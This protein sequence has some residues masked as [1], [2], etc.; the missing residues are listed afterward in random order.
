MIGLVSRRHEVPSPNSWGPGVQP[1]EKCGYFRP[2]RRLE[3]AI[4]LVENYVSRNMIGRSKMS[5]HSSQLISKT[6]RQGFFGLCMMLEGHN[7]KRIAEP[8]FSAK[9]PLCPNVPNVP[10]IDLF[11]KIS[12]LG[13]E[14]FSVL[15]PKLE[16][17]KA[18]K[19]AQL[20]ISAKFMF[21]SKTCYSPYAQC[22]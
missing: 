8:D 18:S 14:F 12:K 16:A 4:S 7:G 20:A 11:K 15:C 13:H 5:V 22:A 2:S 9:F 10:K 3:I 19:M 6:A 21:S 17:N 1:L